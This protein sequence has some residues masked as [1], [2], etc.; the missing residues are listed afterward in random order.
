M[1]HPLLYEINTRCWLRELSTSLGR[2]ATLADVPDAALDHWQALGFTHLWLMGVWPTGPRSRALALEEPSLRPAYTEAL[3]DWQEADVAG[4]PYAVAEYEVATDLGG[5][6]ALK[7]LRRRLHT[8][9]LKLVLDFIPNHTGL[10]HP[11][12]TRH[13]EYFVQSEQHMPGGFALPT[14]RDHR[15]LA[16]GRD[17]FFP[18]WTDTAQLDYRRKDTRRVM[19]ATLKDL[20]HI[21]D[22]VRCDMAMLVLN[23][24]FASTWAQ[25]PG[26]PAPAEDFW[27]DAIAAVKRQ[28]PDFLFLAEAYWNTQSRLHALGFDYSYDKTLLDHLCARAPQ[29]VQRHLLDAPPAQVAA[30]AHFL[31]NHDEPRIATRLSP[32]EHRA[33]ALLVLGLPG[34]RLLHEGQLIGARLRSPVQL[35]RRAAEPTDPATVALYDELLTALRQTPVGRGEGVLLRPRAGWA[36]NPT[37]ENLVLIQWQTQPPDFVLVVVN[38]AP[39]AAQGYA[40]LTVPA[41]ADFDWRLHDRLSPEVWDRVGS[42]LQTQGLY[43]D[44]PAHAAQCFHFAPYQ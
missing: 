37:H 5:A 40:P 42:D 8:R 29:A 30:G 10:D 24:L 9:G 36:G 31:E 43:L 11:W 44:V 39:H 14:D 22:G 16:H 19:A 33:A 15:W 32:A 34:L 41:L 18:P 28:H 27:A 38:L 2:A 7:K 4:S 3:P 21:C 25:Y 20:A 23:D 26:G 1:N 6:S 17:P 13:P 12:L 35:A